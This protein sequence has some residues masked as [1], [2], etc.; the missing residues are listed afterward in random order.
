MF[1]L[2]A[3]DSGYV[4]SEKS[5]GTK[6]ASEGYALEAVFVPVLIFG[7]WIVV[8]MLWLW[9]FR[10]TQGVTESPAK[11]SETTASTNAL[12]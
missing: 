5:E 10:T 11:R 1:V 2:G 4:R 8:C 7:A 12:R 3:K 6:R 9:D